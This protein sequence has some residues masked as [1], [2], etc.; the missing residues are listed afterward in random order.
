ML[1][2][3]VFPLITLVAQKVAQISEIAYYVRYLDEK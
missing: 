3:T 2:R 1:L